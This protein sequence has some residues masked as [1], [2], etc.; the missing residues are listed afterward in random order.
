MIVQEYLLFLS[1]I[2]LSFMWKI[3][4]TLTHLKFNEIFKKN[5]NILSEFNYLE[6][7]FLL[8]TYPL[9]NNLLVGGLLVGR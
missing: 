9:T 3:L 8:P 1:Q 2:V 6:G 5:E 7:L 4:C